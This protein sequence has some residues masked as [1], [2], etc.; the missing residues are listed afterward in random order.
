MLNLSERNRAFSVKNR[1][2][3]HA[4]KGRQAGLE[5]SP[6]RGVLERACDGLGLPTVE[7]RGFS[8]CRVDGFGSP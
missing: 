2:T 3:A 1:D 7:A 6:P 4:R 5:Q 8:R